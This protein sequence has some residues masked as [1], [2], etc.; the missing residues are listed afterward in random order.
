MI[1]KQLFM[2]NDP[3]LIFFIEKV[4][5]KKQEQF[6]KC[7]FFNECSII[8]FLISFKNLIIEFVQ[9]VLVCFIKLSFKF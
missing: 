1:Q 2:T 7:L 8:L 3:K 6:I 9:L 4:M 5:K